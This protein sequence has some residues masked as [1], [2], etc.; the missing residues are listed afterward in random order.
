MRKLA[1]LDIVIFVLVLI[2]GLI[3]TMVGTS[4]A[5]DK[6]FFMFLPVVY[7]MFSLGYIVTNYTGI[8]YGATVFPFITF[9]SRCIVSVEGPVA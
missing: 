6:T 5:K 7:G 9:C 1:N 2:F 4:I 3:L 8:N